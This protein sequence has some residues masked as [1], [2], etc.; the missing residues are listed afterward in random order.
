[1]MSRSVHIVW[2]SDL[3]RVTNCFDAESQH[4]FMEYRDV[5]RN[6]T[7]HNR[8]ARLE[9]RIVLNGRQSKDT[10]KVDASRT[11]NPNPC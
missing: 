11:L 2:V 5:V 9:A 3:N 6:R 8:E 4:V 7:Q 10:A 1:M